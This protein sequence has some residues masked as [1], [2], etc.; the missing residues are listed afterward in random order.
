MAK[1]NVL[2]IPHKRL[3]LA[4]EDFGSGAQQCQWLLFLALPCG[5]NVF[6]SPAP[7]GGGDGGNWQQR[8]DMLGQP[9]NG[10]STRSPDHQQLCMVVKSMA[11][12]VR[13][14]LN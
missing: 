7:T 14:T 6:P 12:G 9:S 3:T 10:I 11:F 5:E 4:A 13:Q 1:T 2:F 8:W